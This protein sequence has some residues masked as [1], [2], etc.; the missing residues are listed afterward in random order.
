MWHK[1]NKPTFD[2]AATGENFIIFFLN[3]LLYVKGS[4]FG[5]EIKNP[6]RRSVAGVVNILKNVGIS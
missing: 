2:H 3:M 1:G 5:M 6:Q 4:A